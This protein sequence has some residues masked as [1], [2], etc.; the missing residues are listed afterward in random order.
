[1]IKRPLMWIV[2]SY[3]IGI[4]LASIHVVISS[5][6]MIAFFVL[7]IVVMLALKISND[8]INYL[9]RFV[10]V[11]PVIMYLGFILM[12]EQI[13]PHPMEQFF[14]DK[15]N[16]V[17]EGTVYR[18]DEKE[19]RLVLY[20]K[21]NSIHISNQITSDKNNSI[22]ISSKKTI[23]INNSKNISNKGISAVNHSINTANREISNSRN[24]VELNK[25]INQGQT[26][27]QQT[28]SYKSG[29]L[30]VYANK[31]ENIKIGNKVNIDGQI[32]KFKKP[33]NL[34]QF[35]E[36]L[37]Y[38][39]Q[40]IDYKI[41]SK[42]LTITNSSYS[43]YYQSLYEIK[44]RLLSS[45]RS[46]L[47]TRN[48]GVLGAMLLGDK[49]LLDTEIKDL[50][51]ENGISH[52]L[53]ISG[54]HVSL[55][56]LFI[57]KLFKKIHVNQ[58]VSIILSIFFL[59][60]Y[61]ALTNFSV[62][63][64]RAVVMLVVSFLGIL[65]GKTYD[66]LSGLSFSAFIILLQNPTE[67][68]NTGFLLSFGAVLAIGIFVPIFEE[69]F[70]NQD[71]IEQE[72]KM[73]YKEMKKEENEQEEKQR[74]K[75]ESKKVKRE[76]EESKKEKSERKEDKIQVF[77]CKFHIVLEKVPI[78]NAERKNQFIQVIQKL[79]SKGK[80]YISRKKKTYNKIKS[81][82]ETQHYSCS[83][84]LAYLKKQIR[85]GLM[86]SISVNLLTLPI[87]LYYFFS[88]PTYSIFI[89]LI[90]IPLT[91]ILVL[92][93]FLGGILGCFSLGLGQFFIGG[94]HYI[95]LFYEVCCEFFASLPYHMIL[96]GKP[97]FSKIILYYIVLITFF[98]LCMKYKKK[99]VFA[100]LLGL[101]IILI[102]NHNK[103][104]E[105]TFIDV[106]QG[107]GIYM[108]S[109]SGTTYLVDGGSSDVSS[110]GQYRIQ[111]FLHAKGIGV[112]DYAI[113]THADNDHISGLKEMLVNK[114]V[115]IK[116]LILPNTNLVDEAY[117]G[118]EETAKANDIS[119][120]YIERGDV[121]EE[122]QFKITCLHPSRKYIASSRNDYSTVLSIKYGDFDMLLTGDLEEIGEQNVV[123]SN[124][125][126]DYDVLK[127]AHHGSKYSTFR[128][129][130]SIIKPEISI[131]SCGK[132][133]TYGHPHEELLQ[134]LEEVNSTV[135]TTSQ[136]GAIEILTD[137]SN[138]KIH[139][140]IP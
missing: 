15:I 78:V 132:N 20:I 62:S 102:P 113:I 60:S 121:I 77:F 13:R 130:L 4:L 85:S 82:E 38:Q 30:I 91:S 31:I 43:T 83:Y 44:N 61:G 45:Y 98:I 40:D 79:F 127:V 116:N 94:A 56:G 33:T 23:D 133:N 24:G 136:Y 112:I 126:F 134:R 88:F 57:F 21:N 46:L 51:M 100:I 36:Y 108:R 76:D 125:L 110:V 95:L 16:G 26:Q 120:L 89:N 8:Y 131:I 54:L 28:L 99:Q 124:M 114:E 48:A 29:K 123:N 105:I 92:L 59:Y 27:P 32:I 107:D 22:S 101:L 2:I 119:V 80:E 138:M 47:N 68:Y 70:C 117:E 129:F 17:I 73:Q 25:N 128:E 5:M 50:Y 122:D 55:I 104:L 97:S 41:Y 65:L 135:Y 53:A 81:K 137:G 87:I 42:N 7:I 118:L 63:T 111:S 90:I 69:I 109:P 9:D 39:N 75:K 140:F 52:I 34:G 66:L 10:F 3:M 72:S 64:N 14:D 35:N 19:D 74:D 96:V 139:T 18:M 58:K 12:N 71:E 49:N 1:M 6:I 93:A 115:V 106:G 11:L 103:G 67:I 84:L 86:V 37:Y